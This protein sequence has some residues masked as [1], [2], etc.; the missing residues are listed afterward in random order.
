VAGKRFRILPSATGFEEKEM[1]WLQSL[2]MNEIIIYGCVFGIPA[3]AI[4]TQM[5]LG[6][7]KAVFKHRERMAM[8]ERGMHPDELPPGDETPEPRSKQFGNLAETQPYVPD[9]A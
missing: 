4:T 3:F 1:A 7:V 5:V 8:I 9:P 2:K 6:I